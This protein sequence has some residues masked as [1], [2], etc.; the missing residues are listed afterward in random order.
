MLLRPLRKSRILNDLVWSSALKKGERERE[1]T[2]LNKG[3]P[4]VKTRIRALETKV[5]RR[6]APIS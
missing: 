6:G 2:M 3:E 1:T 5:S 4:F